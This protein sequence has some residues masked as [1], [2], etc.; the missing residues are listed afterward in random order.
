MTVVIRETTQAD[1][2]E[3]ADL[4][5]VL[6]YP[7]DAPEAAARLARGNERVFVAED[8]GQIQGLLSVW[9][10]LPIARARPVARVTAMV[11]RP[12]SQGKGIGTALMDRAIDW[13]KDGGCEGIE[14]TSGIRDERETA[15]AFYE[16]RGF[17]R[18]AYRFWLPITEDRV[19]R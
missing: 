9:T 10:Q 2:G 16:S 15:H 4:L 11:V 18:T 8:D 7:V 13:A 3:V 19:D 14:L 12:A 5:G 1:A 6:G 17:Q